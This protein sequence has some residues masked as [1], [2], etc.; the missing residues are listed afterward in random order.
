MATDGAHGGEFVPAGPTHDAAYEPDKFAVKTILAVP[1]AV[2]VTGIIA[3]VITW[4]LFSNIFDPKINNPPVEN[5]AAAKRNSES[6]NDRLARISSSDAKAEIQQPR[7]EGMK[8]TQ[9]Y[10]RDNGPDITAEMTTTKP[11]EEGNAPLY[12]A[13]DLRPEKIKELTTYGEDKQTGTARIPV[14]KAIEL[15]VLGKLLPQADGARPLDVLADWNRPKESN[16]GHGRVPE[17]SATAK[18]PADKKEP[19]K[20]E[21]D[22]KEPD[23]KNGA[24]KK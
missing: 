22:K 1:A 5:P 10:K 19:E 23:K 13:D 16:G 14:D 18:K 4:L 2:I 20:K 12:H 6:L 7:L 21:P 3:F 8:Q 17:P 9:T 15:A 11:K 24:E